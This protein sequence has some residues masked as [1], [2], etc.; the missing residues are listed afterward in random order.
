MDARLN[1]G[2]GDEEE[3]NY[4]IKEDEDLPFACFLCRNPFVDPVVTPCGH[5]FCEA[6]ALAHHKKSTHC[7][8]C[9]K[10]TYG[11]INR[12]RKLIKH[13]QSLQ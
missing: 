12:A 10:Q 7:A 5:Y 4:E 2:D 11:V 9:S 8:A 6:C 3:H 1:L 13:M